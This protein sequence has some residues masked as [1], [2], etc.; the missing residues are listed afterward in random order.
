MTMNI[1]KSIGYGAHSLVY[2]VKSPMGTD[3]ALKC[4]FTVNGFT[5]IGS[6]HELQ[7]SIELEHEYLMRVK[8]IREGDIINTFGLKYVDDNY[9]NMKPDHLHFLYPLANTDLNYLITTSSASLDFATAKNILLQVSLALEYM[10]AKNFV[11]RDI[12][13]SNIL[14]DVH[15]NLWTCKLC[16]FG[17]TKYF[18]KYDVHSPLICTVYYR[19]PELILGYTEYD[20]SVDV[21]SLGCVAFELFTGKKLVP[22]ISQ[23]APDILRTMYNCLPYDIPM[24]YVEKLNPNTSRIFIG[25]SKT[26]IHDFIKYL[27]SISKDMGM[28]NKSRFKAFVLGC[29]QFDYSKR[30][31][32][33]KVVDSDIFYD[34]KALISTKRKEYPL[35]LSLLPVMPNFPNCDERTWMLERVI[36]IFNNRS[37]YKWYSHRILFQSIYNFERFLANPGRLSM[38]QNDTILYLTTTIYLSY[39]VFIKL[40]QEVLSL[41]DFLPDSLK[42]E[43]NLSS[44]VIFEYN[45]VKHALKYKVFFMTIYDY[46]LSVQKPTQDI[47]KSIFQFVLEGSHR[48]LD[49][50][51]AFEKWKLNKVQYDI[52]C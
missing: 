2:H 24:N 30:F 13:P 14:I 34:L 52:K 16:D 5:G 8:G 32:M 27:P 45:L 40:H 22:T 3:S 23:A 42:T 41:Y 21:W 35:A 43:H 44:A 29:I 31:S 4:N 37:M 38:S 47:T 7:S 20:K 18:L 46:S 26:I 48:L 11:H 6:Y 1:V 28:L 15:N 17:M 49:P 50:K 33:S 25:M 10:H 36:E 39:K 12:R 51:T 9:L 19:A